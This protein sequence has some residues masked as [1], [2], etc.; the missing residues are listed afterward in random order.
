M[1][2]HTR[3][4]GLRVDVPT[5]EPD[6]VLL[7]RLAATSAASIPTRGSARSRGRSWSVGVRMS[8]VATVVASLGATT[9]A[10]GALAGVDVP[11]RHQQIERAPM[12]PM[13][14]TGSAG[15]PH[16]DASPSGSPEAGLP[17][18]ST[19][20]RH[21]TSSPHRGKGSTKHEGRALSKG[22]ARNHVPPVGPPVGHENGQHHGVNHGHQHGQIG[23]HHGHH[24]GEIPGHHGH[25]GQPGDHSYG[26]DGGQHGHGYGH[27]H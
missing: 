10:A 13:P 21:A 20:H 25:H 12:V 15:T 5:L 8:F 26:H 1:A 14:P 27:G 17:D 23:G 22:H 18:G 16:S 19:A 4:Q 7:D 9:W 24:Y 6:D 2:Q 3:H 11:F